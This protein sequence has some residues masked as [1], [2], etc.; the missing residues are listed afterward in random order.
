MKKSFTL[1]ELLVVIAIIAILAGML[2]PA[3]NKARERARDANCRSSNKQIGIALNLYTNDS[4]GVMTAAYPY[5]SKS[6]VWHALLEDN[7][8]LPDNNKHIICPT[9]SKQPA[10]PY[11]SACLGKFFAGST[12]SDRRFLRESAIKN[13]SMMFTHTLDVANYYPERKYVNHTWYIYQ[14]KVLENS[15][16]TNKFFVSFYGAHSQKGNVLFYDGHV[17]SFKEDDMDND[18]YWDKNLTALPVK[19]AE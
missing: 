19:E 14:W 4:G 7:G 6:I 12:G 1:I 13:P 18:D 11:S 15:Y 2:L 3:L 9:L 5:P 17:D 10:V 8:Y 16:S